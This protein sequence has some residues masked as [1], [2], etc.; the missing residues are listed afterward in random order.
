MKT[1]V[2]KQS[3]ILKSIG[4]VESQATKSVNYQKKSYHSLRLHQPSSK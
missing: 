2:I 4:K 3:R 1:I